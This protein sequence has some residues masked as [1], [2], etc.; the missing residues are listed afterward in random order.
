MSAPINATD[1]VERFID[2][3]NRGDVERAIELLDEQVVLMPMLAHLRSDV[4]PYEGYGGARSFFAEVAAL[5]VAMALVPSQ[6]T[7]EGDRVTVMAT[8]R[9]GTAAGLVD[10]PVCIVVH[11][12]DGRIRLVQSF[13]SVETAR[14]VWEQV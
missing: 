9:T 11:L 6:V 4:R 8:I 3:Y 2:A 12:R 10:H 14:T 7:A 5:P 13:G 1:T